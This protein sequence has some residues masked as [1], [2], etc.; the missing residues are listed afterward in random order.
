[1]LGHPLYL[2]NNTIIMPYFNSYEE[3]IKYQQLQLKIHHDEEFM[4]NINTID[5]YKVKQNELNL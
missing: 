5:K 4:I 3:N 1:V 2:K